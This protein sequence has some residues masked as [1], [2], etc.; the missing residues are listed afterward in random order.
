MGVLPSCLKP[1]VARLRARRQSHAEDAAYGIG[2]VHAQRVSD[3][4]HAQDEGG[5]GADLVGEALDEFPA[6][7]LHPLPGDGPRAG[8][9]EA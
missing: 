7:Q 1:R 9:E 3:D 8:G 5:N 2:R 4:E 6:R